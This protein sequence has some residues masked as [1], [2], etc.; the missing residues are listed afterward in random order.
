MGTFSAMWRTKP[1]AASA[2]D[3][4]HKPPAGGTV[5]GVQVSDTPPTAV[6]RAGRISH[7][8]H[9]RRAAAVA[10]ACFCHQRISRPAGAANSLQAQGL[11][12]PSRMA[13]LVYSDFHVAALNE[14]VVC[15]A[16][17]QQPSPENNDPRMRRASLG[18]GLGT[19]AAMAAAWSLS[20]KMSRP[21]R[22]GRA[23]M[24]AS[25]CSHSSA[26]WTMA[27]GID[28]ER[29]QVEGSTN[30]PRATRVPGSRPDVLSSQ[31]DF[32]C[33]LGRSERLRSCRSARRRLR[34]GVYDGGYDTKCTTVNSQHGI[35][36]NA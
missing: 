32:S 21:R 30:V 20:S 28:F 17:Q 18:S 13:W 24:A 14:P 4:Q 34:H 31:R 10:Y 33:S 3:R 26:S 1:G 23:P 19:C 6:C 25:S 16:N 12:R 15:T 11:W 35:R 2:A 5:V 29:R 27:G 36:S 9:Q 22:R 8:R 7:V